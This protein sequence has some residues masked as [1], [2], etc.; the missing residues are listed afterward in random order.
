[1]T[2]LGVQH[3]R[4]CGRGGRRP[5][6]N[7]VIDHY[8]CQP[9]ANLVGD[10]YGHIV[11]L[12]CDHN[13]CCERRGSQ[14]LVEIVERGAKFGPTLT[15]QGEIETACYQDAVT[16]TVRYAFWMLELVNASA[17]RSA[18]LNWISALFPGP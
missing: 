8:A 15:G 4:C 16:N 1:R 11:S 13:I 6:D 2:L 9:I 10:I 7:S 5:D 3:D 18:R 12:L 14:P 17:C